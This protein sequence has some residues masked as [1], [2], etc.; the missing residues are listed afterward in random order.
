MADFDI[1]E[2]RIETLK[3]TQEKEKKNPVIVFMKQ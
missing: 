2:Q 1:R 3:S